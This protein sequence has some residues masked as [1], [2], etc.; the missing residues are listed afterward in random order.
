M[1]A[2]SFP[3]SPVAK[4]STYNK[5]LDELNVGTSLLR[6]VIVRLRSGSWLVPAIK[7]LVLKDSLVS[8]IRRAGVEHSKCACA[9]LSIRHP[10]KS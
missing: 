1:D 3:A 6:K 10:R 7:L 9:V 4:G 2:V 5:L 8:I